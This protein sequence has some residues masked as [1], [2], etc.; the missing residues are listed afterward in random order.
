MPKVREVA[1]ATG[2]SSRGTG[3][4]LGARLAAAGPRPAIIHPA[5]GEAGAAGTAIENGGVG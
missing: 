5:H 2:G 1:M 3:T 4:A